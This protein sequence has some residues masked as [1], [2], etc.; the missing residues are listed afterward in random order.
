MK[1]GIHREHGDR[2][3]GKETP[4][5]RERGGIVTRE[6]SH[7]QSK[8]ERRPLLRRGDFANLILRGKR[9]HADGYR[10]RE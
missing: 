6:E 5:K 9:R 8:G 7:A 2:H 10:G 1:K 4:L 3:V